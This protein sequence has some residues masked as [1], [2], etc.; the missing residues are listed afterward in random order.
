VEVYHHHGTSHQDSCGTRKAFSSQPGMCSFCWII[1]LCTLQKDWLFFLPNSPRKVHFWMHDWRIAFCRLCRF[2][3]KQGQQ[4]PTVPM[5][6]I[7]HCFSS[8]DC[9]HC[10]KSDHF[11]SQIHQEKSIFECTIGAWR[12]VG[13]VVFPSN[14]YNNGHPCLWQGLLVVLV[15]MSFY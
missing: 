6:R 12:F 13:C 15:P 8:N 3:F 7:A 9:V 11:L 1:T 14:E 2:P 4:W 5:A 10:K